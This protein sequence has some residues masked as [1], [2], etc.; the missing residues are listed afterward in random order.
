MIKYLLIALLGLGC[1]AVAEEWP[2][3]QPAEAVFNLGGIEPAGEPVT[4]CSDPLHCRTVYP[5]GSSWA[6]VPGPGLQFMLNRIDALER[7]TCAVSA[8]DELDEL[9]RRIAVLECRH[10][11]DPDPKDNTTTDIWSGPLDCTSTEED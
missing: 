6:S 1:S 8:N 9:R 11:R 5:D 2:S 10:S 3:S 7:R 4:T